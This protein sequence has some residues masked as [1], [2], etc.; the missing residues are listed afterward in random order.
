VFSHYGLA[1]DDSIENVYIGDFTIEDNHQK[2]EVIT[3]ERLR[4]LRAIKQELL[5]AEKQE[6]DP[7][8]E[9]QLFHAIRKVNGKIYVDYAEYKERFSSKEIL[10]LKNKINELNEKERRNEQQAKKDDEHF[11]Y[12]TYKPRYEKEIKPISE[13]IERIESFQNKYDSSPKGYLDFLKKVLSQE[14][15]KFYLKP[16]LARIPIGERKK[17]TYV[18]AQTGSGKSE[19]LKMLAYGDIEAKNRAVVIIDPHGD[20][21][22]EIARFKRF[23][24]E[25]D[26]DDLVYIDPTL[27]NGFSP[28]INPFEIEDKSENN[29]AITTQELK[30]VINTLLQGSGATAQMEAILSPC[31]SVLLRKKDGCFEDLQRF[32]DDK[33]NSDL[34][35]L[36][37]NSPNPQHAKLFRDKFTSSGYESTKHGIYTRM[38]TL[39]NDPIFQNLI[40]NKTTVNLKQLIDQR[41]T[42]LFKLS[43]GEGGSESMEAFGRFIVGMLRIIA[44][45]RSKTPKEERTPTFFYIDEFQNFVSE[46]IEKALTQLRKYGLHLVLA[47]QYVGQ[48]ID[49]QLQKALFSSGVKIIGKNEIKTAKSAGGEIDVKYDEIKNL[50]IGEFFIQ[51]GSYSALKIKVP[52]ILLG[53]NNAMSKAE[54]EQVENHNLGQYY[55]KT[56][57]KK[58]APAEI[59]K[60]NFKA[61]ITAPKFEL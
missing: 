17:H 25:N 22:E 32:M 10:I 18:V 6:E 53:N 36:G 37:L 16:L 59:Q 13:E 46:D 9:R 27:K 34:I 52:T 5:T 49:T 60:T 51:N 3:A 56:G 8:I 43:L 45:Q 7:Q 31:I 28:S 54:W 39:L 42:I 2:I 12:T 41:K 38:Q 29:I 1:V 19:L 26:Y 40:S 20:M 33:Q 61:P 47:N 11:N 50:K 58:K 4:K 30:R 48:N 35:Q 21:V 15:Y 55:S 44:I 24:P 14:T 23:S 57:T